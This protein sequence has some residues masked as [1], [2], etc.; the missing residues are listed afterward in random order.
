MF[1]RRTEMFPEQPGD[2]ETIWVFAGGFYLRRLDRQGR[3]YWAFERGGY[4]WSAQVIYRLTRP[5]HQPD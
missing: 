4:W 2:V 1:L 5:A 3:R